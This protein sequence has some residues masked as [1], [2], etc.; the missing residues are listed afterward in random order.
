[1]HKSMTLYFWLQAATK[2][3]IWYEH[4][5]VL[6]F[7]GG[8]AASSYPLFIM[9]YTNEEP[10]AFYMDRKYKKVAVLKQ[11]FIITKALKNS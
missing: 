10:G 4:N 2:L 8:G 9:D 5:N 1:M 3:H 11:C 7:A 6:S